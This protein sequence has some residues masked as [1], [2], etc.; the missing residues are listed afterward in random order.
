MLAHAY[1]WPELRSQILQGYQRHAGK[2]VE[3]IEAF[4]A[5]ACARRLLDLTISLTQGAQRMGMNAQATESMRAD[6]EAHR[7]VYRLFTKR[8]GLQIAA[9]DKLFGKSE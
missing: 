3:Q 4:E 2:M 8:T 7:R 1:G 9:F 5:I 6:M